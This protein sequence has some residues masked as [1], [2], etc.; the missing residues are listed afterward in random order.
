MAKS[1]KGGTGYKSP[2]DAYKYPTGTSGNPSGRPK[3][4]KNFATRYIAEVNAKIPIT[5]NGKRK[6][7]SKLDAIIKQQV[8][9]G[10]A[11]DPKAVEQVLHRVSA[12]EAT[13]KSQQA[14]SPFTDADLEVILAVYQ[15][16]TQKDK[17][18]VK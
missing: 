9:R 5:E 6:R 18:D 2:P 13:E 12:L 3:G 8:T 4:S 17:D 14:V 1:T 10:A 16:L 7:V 15:R 11:G